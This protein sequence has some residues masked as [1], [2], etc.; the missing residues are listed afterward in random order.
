MKD[1]FEFVCVIGGVVLVFGVF[2]WSLVSLDCYQYENVTN[3]Q[4]KI[5]LSCYVKDGNTWYSR[6]EFE[7]K[8]AGVTS[9]EK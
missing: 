2:A 7:F 3:R 1:V 8:Q 6:K 4:T 5:G 9:K